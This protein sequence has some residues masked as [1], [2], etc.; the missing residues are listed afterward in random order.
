MIHHKRFNIAIYLGV[1]TV[2]IDQMSK[3]WL[4]HDVN[5]PPT[6]E[7]VN[8]FLNLVMVENRG[9]TFGLLSHFDPKI[10]F[11]F[12]LATAAV[13]LLLLGRWLWLTTSTSVAVGLGL[14]IGGAIGNII[15]RL[16]FGVVVDF[17]DFH[18]GEYHWYAFNI[19]DSAI[20]TGVAILLLD[21]V[22]RG[23][24]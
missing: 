5:P 8:A 22:I 21:S 3:W 23:R 7:R 11:Y 1:F 10:T 4:I 9:V 14:I 2:L 13:I 17:L 18:Y 19:A 12:L 20:V 6:G 24:K 16:R 15:D